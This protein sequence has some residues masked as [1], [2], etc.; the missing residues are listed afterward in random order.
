[1]DR[2][3]EGQDSKNGEAGEAGFPVKELL[4]DIIEV[5]ED[6]TY[7]EITWLRV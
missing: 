1:M 4:C 5:I 2:E 6:T 7:D 3:Q